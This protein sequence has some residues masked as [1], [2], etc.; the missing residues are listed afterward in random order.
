[1]DSILYHWESTL[2]QTQSTVCTSSKTSGLECGA[3]PAA[4]HIEQARRGSRK[5]GF[6]SVVKLPARLC[7]VHHQ[8]RLHDWDCM[9][10]LKPNP[11][12]KQWLTSQSM[13]H[14]DLQ[15]S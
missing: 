6:S 13:Q 7:R 12:W 1:M 9:G 5:C 2:P 10:Q 11:P 14:Q 8:V 4:R 3:G 15:Q